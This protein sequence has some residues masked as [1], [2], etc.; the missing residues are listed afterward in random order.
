MNSSTHEI[1][2]FCMNYQRKYYGQEFCGGFDP[3][4]PV[5]AHKIVIFSMIYE[6]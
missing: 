2:I 6:R 1:V 5:P 3:R 4:I